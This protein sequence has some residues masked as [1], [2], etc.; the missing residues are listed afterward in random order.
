MSAVPNPPVPMRRHVQQYNGAARRHCRTARSRHLAPSSQA[1]SR[2]S[3]LPLPFRLN[4]LND[5]NMTPSHHHN[6]YML[7]ILRQAHTLIHGQATPSHPR[8][9][10]N[11]EYSK[12]NGSR[13]DLKQRTGFHI[14]ARGTCNTS[15]VFNAERR[16][17][18]LVTSC[19]IYA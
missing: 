4:V 16:L 15:I 12:N 11:E 7:H 13:N 17:V 18:D 10:N 3:P 14:V 9:R 8:L 6:E 5:S 19:A 2:I 1:T